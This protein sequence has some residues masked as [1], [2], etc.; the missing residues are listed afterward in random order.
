MKSTSSKSDS[1][2]HLLKPEELAIRWGMRAESLANWRSN[3]E[4]PKYVKLGSG[5]ASN[6]R[7]RL[8]DIL[9]Y[10]QRHVVKETRR[11]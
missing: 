10:E 9:E 1:D 7:Y 6:V 3:G 5:K 11:G 2:G 4:G 8:E